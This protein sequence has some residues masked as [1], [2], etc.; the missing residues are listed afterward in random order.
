MLNGSRELQSQA[1][2]LR[3]QGLSHRQIAKKLGIS[4]GSAFNFTK[5]IRLSW[6]QH[7]SLVKSTGIFVHSK[8]D[9][10]RWSA[11][12][13]NNWL[14]H[15]RYNNPCLIKMIQDFYALN[16][17]VPTKREFNSHWQSYLRVFGSWNSAISAAGFSTNP[18]RF[19]QKYF[20]KDGHKCDSLSEKIIDDW[21]SARK[22]LHTR[23]I[24]YPGQSKFTVDFL[25]EN[26]YW[27]EFFGLLGQLDTYSRLYKRKMSLAKESNIN[28]VNLFPADI[29]PVANLS[30]KLGF[31]LK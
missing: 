15:I 30:Q 18:A 17:R 20:A 27:V 21:L 25:V 31:L 2:T 6:N 13:S 14:S 11:K 23:N 29:F 19:S 22:I 26:K 12:G 7:L 28:I 4:L 1:K 9:R 24:R 5:D 10:A 8:E 3:S 16:G